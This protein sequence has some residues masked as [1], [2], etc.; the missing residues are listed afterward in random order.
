MA[1]KPEP[2]KRQSKR[3]HRRNSRPTCSRVSGD[4]CGDTVGFSLSERRRCKGRRQAER[5]GVTPRI[6]P[7]IFECARGGSRC[8]YRCVVE[9][10]IGVAK[11]MKADAEGRARRLY[12]I[13][14]SAAEPRHEIRAVPVEGPQKC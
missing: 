10:C 14:D 9:A 4:R 3:S 7:S 11:I 13:S 2:K 8:A 5:A 12:C 6:A 1:K